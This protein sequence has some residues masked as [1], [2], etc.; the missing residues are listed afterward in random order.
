M[1]ISMLPF[2][3]IF[4]SNGNCLA[5]IIRKDHTGDKTEFYSNPEY[6]QQ[7]GI[8]KYHIGGK[9]KPHYH[10]KLARQVIY[11][12]EVLFIRKGSVRIDLFDPDL[13]FV[14]SIILKK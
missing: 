11:T 6:S 12:Q 9:I 10:N 3:K 5:M 4:D 1:D 2:Q 13:I 14:D 7:V 8:I